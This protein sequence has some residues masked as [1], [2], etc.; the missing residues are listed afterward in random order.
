ME[1]VPSSNHA[2]Q[3]DHISG[4]ARKQRIQSPDMVQAWIIGNG[5]ASLAAAVYLLQDA[6]LPAR[7]IH[8]LN[9]H[10]GC[11]LK[12]KSSGDAENGYILRTGDLPFFHD[13]CVDSL[14]SR[15][16]STA[17]PCKSILD[18][19]RDS[20]RDPK[21]QCK[22]VAR[23]VKR[24]DGHPEKLALKN[25]HFELKHRCELLKLVLEYERSLK[26]KSIEDIFDASFFRSDAWKLWSTTFA[27]R[28][29]HSAMELRRQLFKYADKL[30]D[31][32]RVSTL[33][34]TQYTIHESIVV[35]ITDF[36]HDE[37]VDLATNSEIKLSHKSIHYGE[38]LTFST[39]INKTRL[40]S[41]TVTLHNS[42]FLDENVYVVWGYGLYPDRIDDYVRK[43]M[44][45]CSGE[46]I[47][48]QLLQQLHFP[49]DQIL[50][51]AITIPM[52][53]PLATSSLVNWFPD[54]RPYVIPKL[55]T[56]LA[57]AGAT[58]RNAV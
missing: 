46:E 8:L 33:H 23:F 7:N 1:T 5:I 20:E 37:G 28:P 54:D 36:L 19:V 11:D 38:P 57:F 45:D 24:G 56:N 48:I 10:R 25:C 35:P 16:P 15:I 31:F 30:K 21:N 53:R 47:L 49:V 14:L 44:L 39:K 18:T 6:R 50:P 52:I 4:D 34:R 32:N 17:D 41:F 40:E 13:R 22:S 42:A 27:I 2:V 55:I 26:G 58:Y 12:V 29:Q 51:A 43:P 3:H 9:A